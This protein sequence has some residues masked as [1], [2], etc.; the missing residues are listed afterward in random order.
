MGAAVLRTPR[1]VLRPHRL[2]DAA[3]WLCIEQDPGVRDGLHGPVRD[4][5]QIL[6]HLR[7]RTRC[8]R[9]WQV[10]DFLALAVEHDGVLIGD[11]SMHLRDAAPGSRTVEVGW[12]QKAQHGGH[13]YA[14]EAARALLGFAFH[15]VEARWVSAVIDADNERSIAV[16][17]RLGF[18]R[19]AQTGRKVTFL[20]DAAPF[21]AVGPV[22][23]AP[24]AECIS[25]ELDL[26]AP[27]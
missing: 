1:L 8:T 16:A 19:V 9:L 24:S 15:A 26:C 14:T 10:D 13:G 18:A 22:E 2:S 27:N 5:P 12:L 6:E 17:R 21:D 4:E 3:A 20:T 7:A 11:V 23:A 25:C